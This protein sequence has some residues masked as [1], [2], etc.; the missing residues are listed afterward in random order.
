[1][2][3]APKAPPFTPVVLTDEPRQTKGP[4]GKGLIRLSLECLFGLTPC[5]LHDRGYIGPSTLQDIG[6]DFLINDIP[7]VD[8]PAATMLRM[9]FRV[10][11]GKLSGMVMGTLKYVAQK[12]RSAMIH[13]CLSGWF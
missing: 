10:R 13:L 3:Y 6:H 1:M 4:I 7:F 9:T 2:V 11:G 5:Q 12:R 8:P